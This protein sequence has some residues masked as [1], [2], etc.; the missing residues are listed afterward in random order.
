MCVRRKE[1]CVCEEE[2]GVCMCKCSECEVVLRRMCMV[3]A[4][5]VMPSLSPRCS[6]ATSLQTV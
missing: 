6:Q 2:G 3:E 1:G 5:S 4:S